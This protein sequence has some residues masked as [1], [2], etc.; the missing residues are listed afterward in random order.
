MTHPIMHHITKAALVMMGAQ[1]P[2]YVPKGVLFYVAAVNPCADFSMTYF[3]IATSG[4]R[5]DVGLWQAG[6]GEPLLLSNACGV[7][8]S[9]LSE[10]LV[11][12]WTAERLKSKGVKA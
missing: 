2:R 3:D 6:A 1:C 9:I 4:N 7:E 5:Y 11:S 12:L 10:T 8:A